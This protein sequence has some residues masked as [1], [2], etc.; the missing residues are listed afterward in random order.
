MKRNILSLVIAAFVAL[1][2]SAWAAPVQVEIFMTGM[3][4]SAVPL[5]GGKVYTYSAGTLAAKSVWLDS[6]KAATH[7]NPLTLDTDG[8]AT[9]Y[10][11]GLYKFVVKDADGATVCTYD[12]LEYLSTVNPSSITTNLAIIA[13]ASITN[14]YSPLAILASSTIS[15]SLLS[16]SQLTN[17]T[18][19]ASPTQNN[20][21]VDYGTYA[22]GLASAQSIAAASLTAHMADNTD[23]HGNPLYQT[24]LVASYVQ[25]AASIVSGGYLKLASYGFDLVGLPSTGEV[26]V[27]FKT[28]TDDTSRQFLGATPR[29]SI[30]FGD[31]AENTQVTYYTASNVNSVD[32]GAATLTNFSIS[33]SALTS[34]AAS[35]ALYTYPQMTSSITT[36]INVASQAA[37][38]YTD[39]AIAAIPAASSTAGA[40]VAWYWYIPSSGTALNKWNVEYTGGYWCV[41]TS[42]APAVTWDR[43]SL[44]GI[45]TAKNYALMGDGYLCGYL[46]IVTVGGIERLVMEWGLFSA[47][48]Y[49]ISTNHVNLMV[50]RLY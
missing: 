4:D 35:V 11:E 22:A 45:D 12:N 44:S 25:Y 49:G 14:L 47:S 36:L 10:A 33:A 39:A 34:N 1:C 7:T 41:A 18:L 9:I 23:P 37:K 50:F 30:K 3:A 8:R 6:A 29:S 24:N 31:D 15:N 42:A 27:Y 32:F 38:D 43:A 46:H 40:P 48:S 17:N 13:S 16:N 5:S 20:H 2:A 28:T 26:G 21:I 19:T